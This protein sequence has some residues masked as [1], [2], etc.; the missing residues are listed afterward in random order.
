MC[1]RDSRD[2]DP[3][4]DEMVARLQAQK[5]KK[6]EGKDHFHRI[7]LML[8]FLSGIILSQIVQFY[9]EENILTLILAFIEDSVMI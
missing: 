9:I 8:A 7:Q 4:V 6:P 3:N 1:I 2:S 5:H